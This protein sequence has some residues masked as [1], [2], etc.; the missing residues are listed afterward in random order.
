MERKL[1][2]GCLGS[3]GGL[4]PEDVAM[5][6]TDDAAVD[7]GKPSMSVEIKALHQERAASDF[8]GISSSANWVWSLGI[9]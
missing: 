2:A 4:A 7:E 8:I 1:H 9:N 6:W 5:L 3:I